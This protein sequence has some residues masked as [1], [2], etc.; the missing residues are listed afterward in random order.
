MQSALSALQRARVVVRVAGSDAGPAVCAGC[1]GAGDAFE[2]A[3]RYMHAR[4]PFGPALPV[5]VRVGLS[6]KFWALL[7]DFADSGL[8]RKG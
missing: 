7:R 3:R 1:G 5:A 8:P 2:W 6:A 4:R